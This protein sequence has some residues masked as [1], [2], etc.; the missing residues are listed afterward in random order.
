MRE[1]SRSRKRWAGEG[2]YE[3]SWNSVTEMGSTQS[4][5]E[6]A[7][8]CWLSCHGSQCSFVVRTHVL[9]VLWTNKLQLHLLQ[10]L[11]TGTNRMLGSRLSSH[12]TR[13]LFST[14][15]SVLCGATTTLGHRIPATLKFVNRISLELHDGYPNALVDFHGRVSAHIRFPS[16][17]T[18]SLC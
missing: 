17:M 7:V 14:Y 9:L 12:E 15:V 8:I 18:Q 2:G 6:D 3:R 16:R 11:R 13:R 5:L 1:V 10:P 4:A